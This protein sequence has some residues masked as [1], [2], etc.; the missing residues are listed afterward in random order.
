VQLGWNATYA[1]Q[2]FSIASVESIRVPSISKSRPE[3]LYGKACPENE[4][5]DGVGEGQVE[6]L[7][8]DMVSGS[9]EL[10]LKHES[11]TFVFLMTPKPMYEGKEKV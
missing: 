7:E 4:A 6:G 5:S 10:G 1:C 9:S 2:Y 11:D 8:L 3:N